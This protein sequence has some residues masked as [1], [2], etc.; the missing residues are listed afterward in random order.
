MY[1]EFSQ[2]DSLF[3]YCGTV[4]MPATAKKRLPFHPF[5]FSPSRCWEIL[6]AELNLS[7]FDIWLSQSTRTQIQPE[8]MLLQTITNVMP[9]LSAMSQSD[10]SS[11]RGL[12]MLDRISHILCAFSNHQVAVMCASTLAKNLNSGKMRLAATRI[13]VKLTESRVA[14]GPANSMVQRSIYTDECRS[15]LFIF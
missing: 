8:K 3:Y 14:M 9:E 4:D 10:P 7:N 11:L 13:M 15:S 12:Q 5:V 2:G 1:M 6:K